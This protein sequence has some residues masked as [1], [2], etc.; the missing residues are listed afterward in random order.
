YPPSQLRE[1]YTIFREALEE[2]HPSLYWFTPKDSMDMYF[3]EGLA[4][5]A[6][7]MTER[8]FRTHLTRVVTFLRCGHTSVNYSRRYT[9]YLDTA[10]EPMFP[11]S[12]KILE[13]DTLVVTANLN[14]E[15]SVLTRG[16]VVTSVNGHPAAQLIDTFLQYTTGDGYAI[17]GRYQSLS[18]YGR[19]GSMYKSL[20][21][22]TDSFDISYLTEYGTEDKYKVPVFTPAPDTARK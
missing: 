18:T 7:S 9:N 10:R 3:D 16:T 21:D 2:M 12:F 20:F 11:L 8:Q 5:I 22:L 6:D 19:F 17:T 4:H 15:D 14:P 1:D 13:G